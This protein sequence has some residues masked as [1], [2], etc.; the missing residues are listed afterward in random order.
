MI[1]NEKI[2]ATINSWIG[3]TDRF[4]VEVKSSPSKIVVY[5]DKPT[6]I[7]LQECAELSRLI[8][9]T[10]EPEGVWE[11]HELEVSSPGM[12]QPLRVYQQYL[13]RIGRQ[14]RVVTREGREHKGVISAA[15]ESGFELTET[16]SRK[17]NKKK[18]IT[19]TKNRFG[20]DLIKETKLIL[21]FKNN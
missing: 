19:E 5:I 12:D 11:T 1:L 15:D 16:I 17:E 21:T 14:A 18:I 20:Y 2:A 13:R 7:T 3:T 6:G 10:L 8:S 9:E 4:L